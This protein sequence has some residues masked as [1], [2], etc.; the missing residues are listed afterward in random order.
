[1]RLSAIRVQQLP[2]K[3]CIDSVISQRRQSRTPY[4]H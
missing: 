1:L 2:I 3:S 4:W